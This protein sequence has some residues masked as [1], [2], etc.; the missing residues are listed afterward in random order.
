MSVANAKSSNPELLRELIGA[1][2]A[3][4]PLQGLLLLCLSLSGVF[5]WTLHYTGSAL[6]AE[7]IRS[8]GPC[9][10]ERLR[11]ELD[12]SNQPVTRSD[13]NAAKKAC[14]TIDAAEAQRQIL[15]GVG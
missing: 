13:L 10:Q 14:A 6:P 8:A 5:M 15:K 3:N 9:V 7:A 4:G 2:K 11:A 1:L 12:A